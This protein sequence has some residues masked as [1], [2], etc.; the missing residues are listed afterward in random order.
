MRVRLSASEWVHWFERG[1]MNAAQIAY[2]CENANI[3]I[4]RRCKC[5]ANLMACIPHML[6]SSSILASVKSTNVNEKLA[7]K[8]A[9]CRGRV[10]TN[11]VVNIESFSTLQKKIKIKIV[12][13]NTMHQ[14]LCDK[15]PSALGRRAA[16]RIAQANCVI[17]ASLCAVELSVSFE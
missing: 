15:K 7:Q 14:T 6:P 16:R 11:G 8:I 5:G 2:N 4:A 3:G 12:V 9:S 1:G 17:S 10:S 13:E